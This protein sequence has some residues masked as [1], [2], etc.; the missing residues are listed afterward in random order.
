MIKLP[1]IGHWPAHV[2]AKSFSEED[3]CRGIS[4]LELVKREVVI[5]G[6][7]MFALGI[8]PLDWS[9]EEVIAVQNRLSLAIMKQRS[10]TVMTTNV[11]VNA[12]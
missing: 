8:S 2:L 10:L 6:P 7:E 3:L 4:Y 12:A 9:V 5:P 1:C 11:V